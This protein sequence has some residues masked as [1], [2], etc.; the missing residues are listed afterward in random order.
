MFDAGEPILILPGDYPDPSIIRVGQDYYMTHSSFDYTPGLLIWHSRDLLSWERVGYAIHR[1]IGNIQAPELIFYKG[2]YYI[3]F[4]AGPTNWV[5][6]AESPA[7]PWSEPVDLNVGLIDPGHAAD[8]EG[9]RYLFLS[10]GHRIRLATDGL[11]TVGQLV[12]VYEG[13][14][15]PS[16]WRTEGFY[17]ES[18]KFTYRDGCYYMTSA[19][20]GTAGPATSHMIVTARAK[21]LH[22]PWENSPYNPVLRTWHR[23]ERWLSKGHGT[24]VDT[25][26]GRWFVVYRAYEKDYATL[27]R[28][29]LMEPVRWDEDGW[30][31]IAE[32]ER[33][34]AENPS[35]HPAAA[36]SLSDRFNSN[37]LSPQWHFYGGNRTNEY[38][39]GGGR[40]HLQGLPADRIE[41]LL[42]I[43]F[44][45]AYETSVTVRVE[46]GAAGRLSLFYK[47]GFQCG[48][49]FDGRRVFAFRNDYKSEH[50]EVACGEVTLRLVN[51]RHEVDLY[52]R[53]NSDEWRKLDHGFEM[54]GF[55]NNV[56]G[57]FLSLRIA[58]DATG[59]GRA[60]FGDISYQA[61]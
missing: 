57:S 1:H 42:C 10:G 6:T 32:R 40:L 13:W 53:V 5:V 28:Q 39:V 25:P 23:D 51:D 16:E 26:D 37:E 46:E 12:Q 8:A 34:V 27:G 19:Q 52:Y 35:S 29:T 11:A 55:H 56:L 20:G 41:P 14:R 38:A 54:S 3:Y 30:F 21:S 48:I 47:P 61:G 58:L 9:S 60:I 24:L 2:L 4:P 17:L 31:R 49:G 44:H 36:I 45:H 22:G 18:P 50:T 33:T 15:Y 59:E 43:P 7:G